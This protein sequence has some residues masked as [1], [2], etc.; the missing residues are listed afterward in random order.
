MVSYL[1]RKN[2]ADIFT[3]GKVLWKDAKDLYGAIAFVILNNAKEINHYIQLKEKLDFAA[4]SPITP[5]GASTCITLK[6]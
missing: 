1:K 6:W 3:K 4:C 5:I 2:F